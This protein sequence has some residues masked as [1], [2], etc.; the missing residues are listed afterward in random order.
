MLYGILGLLTFVG[1]VGALLGIAKPSP[2]FG[3]KRRYALLFGLVVFFGLGSLMVAAEPEDVKRERLVAQA[4]QA[5]ED[6]APKELELVSTKFAATC[7]GACLTLSGVISN[8]TPHDR[9]DAV[10]KCNY[11]GPSGSVIASHKV[12]VYRVVPA[13]KQIRFR[14][15]DAGFKPDQATQ[16]YCDILVSTKVG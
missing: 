10:I 13:G 8:P 12:T 1:V 7:G 3:G 2:I 14:G 6:A 4:E 9:K 11:T 5:K 15:L 16:S